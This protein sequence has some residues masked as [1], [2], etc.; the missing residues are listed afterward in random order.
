M[1]EHVHAAEETKGFIHLP[2][3]TKNNGEKLYTWFIK[4]F[5]IYHPSMK[6]NTV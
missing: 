5:R 1:H 4:I 2:L 3:E 6:S